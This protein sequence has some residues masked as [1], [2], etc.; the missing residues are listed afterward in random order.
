MVVPFLA[1]FHRY[2]GLEDDMA[3]YLSFFFA[4]ILLPV[5]LL[6]IWKGKPDIEVLPVDVDDPIMTEMIEKSKAEIG[7]FL[8]GL[9]EGKLEA[10]IKFPLTVDDRTEHVWGIAH[11]KSENVIITSLASQPVGEIPEEAYERISVPLAEI[12]DWMLQDASGKS[13][14]GYTMLAMAKIYEREYGKLPKKYIKD[15][16]PFA[17]LE[18]HNT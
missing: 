8:K 15:L 3:G 6:R 12:E 10:L 18:W 14:G 1:L 16:E 17:D 11:A 7:R 2:L 5:I 13:Y 4:W 9:E